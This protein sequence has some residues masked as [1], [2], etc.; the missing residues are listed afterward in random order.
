MIVE[1]GIT[2]ATDTNILAGGRLENLPAPGTVSLEMS[3][4][5]NTAASNHTITVRTP[6]SAGE[7]PIDG[8]PVPANGDGKAGCIDNNTKQ[9]LLIRADSG[10]RLLFSTVMTGTPILAWR[11]TYVDVNGR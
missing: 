4:D 11:A 1:T 9:T 7:V 8:Q 3:S 6:D 5:F 10:G 2:V